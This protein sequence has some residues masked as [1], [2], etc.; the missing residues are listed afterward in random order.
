[1]SGRLDE[2]TPGKTP[3]RS[4]RNGSEET[5]KTVPATQLNRLIDFR[6]LSQIEAASLIGVTQPK[7]SQIRRYRLQNISQERL[8]QALIALDQHVEVVIR[9]AQKSDCAAITVA[10]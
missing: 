2:G 6:N 9:P 7:V 8:M 1:M 10:A 3:V 4:T 5:T